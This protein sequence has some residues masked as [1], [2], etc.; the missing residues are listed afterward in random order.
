VSIKSEIA[1]LYKNVSVLENYSSDFTKKTILKHNFVHGL[2]FSDE[3]TPME[4][5]TDTIL[6][7]VHECIISTDMIHHFGLLDKL[8]AISINE[9]MPFKAANSEASIIV[10]E[11][12]R[13]L[14][15]PLKR[16]PISFASFPIKYALQAS[17]SSNSLH[18]QQ[19]QQQQFKN[20]SPQ[21]ITAVKR[22]NSSSSLW[23]TK[24][25]SS[26][27]IQGPRRD[28]SMQSLSPLKRE[29]TSYIHLM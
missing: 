12:L 1:E 28:P 13:D 19:I 5:R 27:Q 24:R 8:V 11:H 22:D 14:P 3:I 4:K 17:K 20:A 9:N 15:I 21:M 7:I 26:N 25:D 29:A 10:P 16:D 18:M 2:H 23:S 6:A